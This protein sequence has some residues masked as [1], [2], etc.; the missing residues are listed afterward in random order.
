MKGDAIEWKSSLKGPS[1]PLSV[2]AIAIGSWGI[3]L[4]IVNIIIGA[5]SPGRK[6][7]WSGFILKSRDSNTTS[8]EMVIDDFIFLGLAVSLCIIG[9]LNIK[10]SVAKR[11]KGDSEDISIFVQG[12]IKSFFNNLTTLEKGALKFISSW[13]ISIGIIFYLVWSIN[14]NTWIDPGVYSVM[15]TF[16]S[17]GIGIFILDSSKK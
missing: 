3:I 2:S 9:F 17:F 16:I 8:F 4:S 13:L 7:L 5:Y 12:K 14:Y 15:I 11:P 6:A 1:M 10:K